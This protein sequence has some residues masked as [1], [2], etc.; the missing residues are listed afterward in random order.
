MMFVA[1]EG[2]ADPNRPLPLFPHLESQEHQVR[3]RFRDLAQRGLTVGGFAHNLDP[4]MLSNSLRR[5]SRAIGSSSTIRVL[6]F[7]VEHVRVIFIT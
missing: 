5:T 3:L 7:M 2:R 4:A 1:L 6:K